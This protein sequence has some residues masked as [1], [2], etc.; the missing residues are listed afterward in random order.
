[1]SKSSETIKWLDKTVKMLCKEFGVTAKVV[2]STHFKILFS[3]KS[4]KTCICVI[5]KTT[6]DRN[7]RRIEIALIRREL[8]KRLDISVRNEYFTLQY[9]P[10]NY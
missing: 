9:Q 8:K 6:S 4:G 10:S 3:S 2:E 1:M 7:V 5:S